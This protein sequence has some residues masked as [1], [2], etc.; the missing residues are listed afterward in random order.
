[1]KGKVISINSRKGFIAIETSDGITAV[2]LLG[3][4]DVVLGVVVSGNLENL[5]GVPNLR[6]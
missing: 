4:Y 2:E 6:Q 5:G 3:A 1:M